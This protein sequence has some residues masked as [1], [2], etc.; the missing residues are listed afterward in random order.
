M[1][2]DELRGVANIYHSITPHDLAVISLMKEQFSTLKGKVEGP[3]T[4][5]PFD[6]VMESIKSAKKVSYYEETINGVKGWW[7]I[8][9]NDIDSRA[10]LYFHGGAYN[11]GSSRAY[12]NFAGNIAERA[13]LSLFI[14]DYR[15]APENPYPAAVEDA[16]SAYI[17]LLNKGFKN[18]SIMGDSAGGGLALVTMAKIA[19]QDDLLN[20]SSCTVFSPWTDLKLDSITM[21][22][23]AENDILLARASLERDA[24]RYLNGISPYDPYV[25][26]LYGSLYRLPPI[27]I[28]VGEAEILLGDSLRYT[29]KAIRNNTRVDLHIWEGMP[30]V[31]PSNLGKLDAAE[32][33]L[34]ITA[35]FILWQE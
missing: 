8:P 1:F 12:R 15:L 23:K 13:N 27:Q 18:I 19:F 11:V 33:A 32:E 26:P 5:A 3:Q 6:Q 28:H 2:N 25:S 35:S 24:A 9:N 14:P 31:F 7:C 4:R 20:P 10:I 30:H 29:E 17:G 16:Q 21:Q 34:N 22:S